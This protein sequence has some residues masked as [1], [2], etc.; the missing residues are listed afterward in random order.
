MSMTQNDN[1]RQ[2]LRDGVGAILA[3]LDAMQEQLD[4][5]EA[6]SSAPKTVRVSAKA[7]EIQSKIL[8]QVVKLPPN[9]P[10]MASNLSKMIGEENATVGTQLTKLVEMGELEYH[11]EQ[12][13]VG[14]YTRKIA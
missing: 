8:E 5:M 14:Y 4:R 3:R 6:A 9:F 13:A 10:F 7:A 12:G 11:K 2:V 1:G